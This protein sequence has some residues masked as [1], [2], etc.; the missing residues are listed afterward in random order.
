MTPFEHFKVSHL[1]PSQI[2]DMTDC[3]NHWMVGRIMNKLP[4][5]TG[6]S[7]TARG[8]AVEHA[9]YQ[10][11]YH[12]KSDDECIQA[13]IDNYIG[14]MAL[15]PDDNKQKERDNIEPMFLQLAEPLAEYGDPLRANNPR[16][17]HEINLQM[18]H[19]PRMIGYLDLKYHTHNMVI[20]IKTTT[21][22]PSSIPDSH[23]RQGALYA[24]ATGARVRFAY[25][26]PKK[27]AI[28]ELE[29]DQID[30]WINEIRCTLQRVERLLNLSKDIKEV[31][32]YTIPNYASWAWKDPEA[33]KVGFEINGY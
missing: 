29:Q 30:K 13:G 5:F 32:K 31:V 33:R 14:D 25:A 8:N 12:N 7:A 9:L 17:Q 20:D 23:A 18:L 27:F 2:N 16:E 28:Y 21:R 22:L 6:N 4:K 19:Y 11:L 1:S 24:Q 15:K 3:V 26:T 10:K